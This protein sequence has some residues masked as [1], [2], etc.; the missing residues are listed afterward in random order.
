MDLLS[1]D[2]T[3]QQPVETLPIITFKPIFKTVLWGGKR[4]AEF[5][6]LPPQGDHI[7]ESWDM[8]PMPDRESTVDSGP[9][10]GFTL[11]ELIRLYGT[12]LC[13]RIPV[14]R[15]GLRFPLLL[16]WLDTNSDLSIQVHPDGALSARRHNA[17]GKTEMWYCVESTPE[18][19]LY[20]GFNTDITPEQF[21]G[22]VKEHTIASLLNRFHPRKGDVFFIPAGRVHSLGAGNLV[23]EIQEASDI[24]YRIYDYNRLD[25]NGQPRQLHIEESID[26]LD[27]SAPESGIKH[28]E[29]HNGHETLL[30]HCPQFTATIIN[31]A[32]DMRLDLSTRESFTI[33]ASVEGN[34]TLVDPAGNRTALPQGHSALV[35]ASMPAVRIMPDTENC[36]IVTAY[37]S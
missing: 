1:L 14:E 8:S 22:A 21:Q 17:N 32:S 30:Q 34:A 35:P 3:M 31:T 27:F 9:L 6:G 29:P 25:T 24:T 11:G 7:G 20:N 10:K 12:E 23:L 4:I 33:L 16:K 36:S 18:A 37:I 13:G 15:Y 5:K 2:R 26:A 19:Y 28:V